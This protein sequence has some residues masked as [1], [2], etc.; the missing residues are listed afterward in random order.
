MYKHRFGA[1]C[2]GVFLALHCWGIGVSGQNIP[3]WMQTN[4]VRAHDKLY[5]QFKSGDTNVPLLRVDVFKGMPQTGIAHRDGRLF[6]YQEGSVSNYGFSR[7]LG[8]TNLAHLIEVMNAL[9]PSSKESIPLDNQIHISGM[10]GNQWFHV[11]YDIDAYPKEVAEICKIFGPPFTR[12][13][14]FSGSLTN[15]A[16]LKGLPK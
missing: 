7:T 6:S 16:K 1:A 4:A 3:S 12:H 15:A 2:L 8:P 14:T 11:T 5:S 10:R 13:P 9:P